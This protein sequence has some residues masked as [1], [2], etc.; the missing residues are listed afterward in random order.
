VSNRDL[1]VKWLRVLF[2]CQL[3]LME[4]FKDCG[5]LLIMRD[6]VC[7]YQQRKINIRNG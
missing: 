4:E 2:G 6:G 1:V 3:M 7:G 5:G